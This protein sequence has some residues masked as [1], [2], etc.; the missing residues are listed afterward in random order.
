[1]R[2]ARGPFVLRVAS[3]ASPEELVVDVGVPGGEYTEE[4]TSAERLLQGF[5]KRVSVLR[6]D[7]LQLLQGAPVVQ[8]YRGGAVVR[9]RGRLLIG[10]ADR[11]LGRSL[12]AL[13]IWIRV[14]A[15]GIGALS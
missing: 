9:L 1:M 5:S 8:G 11:V 3:D 12:G 7:A 10:A 2:A 15:L 4:A 6:W 14:V 13:L